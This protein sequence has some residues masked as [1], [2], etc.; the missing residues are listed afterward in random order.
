MAKDKLRLSESSYYSFFSARLSSI[1]AIILLLGAV[2]FLYAK[3]QELERKFEKQNQLSILQSTTETTPIPTP[4]PT[5]IKEKPA[6]IQEQ[7]KPTPIPTERKKVAVT[8]TDPTVAGVWYCYEDKANEVTTAQ[9]NLNMELSL[10][11]ICS[12]GIQNE[13]Y[14][15]STKCKEISNNCIN[16]CS[17]LIDPLPCLHDCDQSFTACLGG[18]PKGTECGDKFSGKIDSLRSQLQQLKASYCP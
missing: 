3:N 1:I 8:L 17:G 6:T 4:E 9:N 7:A 11:K 12:S 5:K 15:C 13:Y 2:G 14:I 10:M 16:N 18:C